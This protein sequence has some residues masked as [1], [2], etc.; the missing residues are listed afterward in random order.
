ME[1]IFKTEK[2]CLKDLGE[3]RFIIP[4]Y[5]RPYVWGDEQINKLLSDFYD[6]YARKDSHY[7][8]G[9]ALTSIKTTGADQKENIHELI[10]GQQRFTT[11]WLIAVSFKILKSETAILHYLKSG[12]ELRFDFA[13]RKQLKSYLLS[14]LDKEKNDKNQYTDNEVESDEYLVNIAKA[15]TTIT[16]KI[17]TFTFSNGQSINNFGDYIYNNVYFVVNTAPQHTNLN[18]LFAT[19]NNSG[20]QLEQSD[21]LKSK[22]LKHISKTANSNS[23]R[24]LYSRIWEACENMENFFE[25]NVRK[26]FAETKW[27]EVT[28]DTFKEFN[29]DIFKYK[30]ETE[31]DLEGTK[32]FKL[33]EILDEKVAGVNVSVSAINGLKEAD[34]ESDVVYCRSIIKF[35]QLLLHT[36]RVYLFQQGRRDFEQPFHSKNLLSIFSSLENENEEFI[37]GFFLC[38]WK[39][40]YIFDRCIVKWIQKSEDKEEEL[41]LTSVTH[42]E[43]SN[44]RFFSRKHTDSRDA[45][46]MLQSVLYFTGNYNTQ[47]WLSP[48]L[49]RLLDGEEPLTCLEKIDNQLS[50]SIEEDKI[51]S[52]NLMNRDFIVLNRFDYQGY[53]KIKEEGKEDEGTAFKHYWFQK[54]EYLLWK[55]YCNKNDWKDGEEKKFKEYRITSKNSVEHIFPQNHEFKLVLDKHILDCFGNLGLLSVSQNSSYSNQDVKKKRIDFF[56]KESFDSLKLY[57]IYSNN[58]LEKLNDNVSEN[59]KDRIKSILENHLKEMIDIL[60]EHYINYR[61]N[62]N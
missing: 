1:R 62:P 11:L 27:T 13:I 54:L 19:I 22:L 48:F 18:K 3:K 36:Y 53:L 58:E 5:Q 7:L 23:E 4:S 39:V 51:T 47:I 26:L 60:N 8:I 9:T 46:S 6:A 33:S 2:Y 44:N 32:G 14:L 45:V 30:T 43:K 59:N 61:I 41:K 35:P 29:P 38:L 57:H 16:K 37:K 42:S 52:F 55:K 20:I 40:R 49:K 21:I 17:E 25:R 15:V 56:N 28:F 31:S 12:E 34:D 50:L 10:D 24:I